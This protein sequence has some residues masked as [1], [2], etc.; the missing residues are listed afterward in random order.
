MIERWQDWQRRH[1]GVT[2]ALFVAAIVG[3][4]VGTFTA[5]NVGIAWT[6]AVFALYGLV[7]CVLFVM[8]RNERATVRYTR[9]QWR[10]PR[11]IPRR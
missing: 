10:P 8:R 3:G 6:F 7:S 11:S 1:V 4:I 2:V 5:P 9:D